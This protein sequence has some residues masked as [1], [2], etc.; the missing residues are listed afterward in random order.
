MKIKCYAHDR[1]VMMLRDKLIPTE[2]IIHRDDG[3]HC[4]TKS[5]RQGKKLFLYRVEQGTD[6]SIDMTRQPT[7]G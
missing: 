5:L 2:I 7:D 1:R 4:D 3:S 6:D